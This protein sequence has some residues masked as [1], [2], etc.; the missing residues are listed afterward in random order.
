MQPEAR[1]PTSDPLRGTIASSDVFDRRI[2][3]RISADGLYFRCRPVNPRRWWR[4]DGVIGWVDDLS[5]TG[6]RLRLHP[7]PEARLRAL[8]TVRVG[9]LEGEVEICN[10]SSMRAGVPAATIG[11][12]FLRLDAELRHLID[13]YLDGTHTADE[14]LQTLRRRE[15]RTDGDARDPR[16]GST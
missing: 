13:G 11:V 15:G 10:V 12:R 1:P 9:S 14:W 16:P 7:T 8:W 2:A 5:S 4:V 6:A 3:P